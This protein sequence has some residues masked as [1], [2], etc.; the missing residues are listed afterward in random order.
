MFQTT[1]QIVYIYSVK[2]SAHFQCQRD[3]TLSRSKKRCTY[4][5]A[6]G[7]LR[8]IIQGIMQGMCAFWLLVS[9]RLTIPYHFWVSTI[10]DTSFSS[11]Q[12]PLLSF[13]A[14]TKRVFGFTHIYPPILQKVWP[15]LKIG[16]PLNPIVYQCLS[17][18]GA[19]DMVLTCFNHLLI[20][21]HPIHLIR[22]ELMLISLKR[23]TRTLEV[24]ENSIQLPLNLLV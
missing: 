14:S 13:D 3:G 5:H 9:L 16:H 18:P 4:A 19:K 2:A 1:N 7:G 12:D 10:N 8:S 15:S 24:V 23:G 11:V 22:S 17:E 6:K 20:L 21:F